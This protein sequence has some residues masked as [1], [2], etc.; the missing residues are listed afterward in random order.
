MVP[1]LDRN[2]LL[3]PGIHDCDWPEFRRRFGGNPVRERLLRGLE[4]ALKALKSAGCGKAYIDGSFVT[5]KSEPNDYD[6]CW[7]KTNVDITKLDPVLL[8]FDNG[9][10]AQKMKYFGELFPASLIEGGSNRLFLDFFQQNRDGSS[11]GIVCIDL[12]NLQ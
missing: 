1:E 10:I 8:L 11:K 4:Q 6:G 7:D 3:P 9:R 5:S 2:G 12:R